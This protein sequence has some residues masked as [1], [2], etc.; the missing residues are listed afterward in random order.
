L[1]RPS[2]AILSR[3]GVKFR[4]APTRGALGVAG[5]GFTQLYA[6]LTLG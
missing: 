4:Y 3:L 2:R 6:S 5:G 1:E